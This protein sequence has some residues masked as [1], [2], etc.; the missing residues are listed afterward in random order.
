MPLNKET[1]TETSPGYEWLLDLGMIG[2]NKSAY[3]LNCQKIG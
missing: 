2:I 1:E 3:F